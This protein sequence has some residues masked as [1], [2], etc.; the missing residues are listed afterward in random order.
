MKKAATKA[1]K[2]HLS[3]IV[4]GGCI[5]PDCTAPAEVHHPREFVGLAQREEHWLAIPLCPEHHRG[6]F[7]IH[8]SKLQFENICGKE[9]KLIAET[10]RRTYGN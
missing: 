4:E 2:L 3:R 5:L 9:I 8:G 1:E 7:S 6:T 10:I